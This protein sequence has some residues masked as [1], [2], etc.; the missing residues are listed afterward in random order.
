MNVGSFLR[1]H[2]LGLRGVGVS[3]VTWKC[4]S[5]RPSQPDRVWPWWLKHGAEVSFLGLTPQWT[6]CP[7]TIPR[8]QSE[9]S[10]S[11]VVSYV[12]PFR[13]RQGTKEVADESVHIHYFYRGETSDPL[14]IFPKAQTNPGKAVKSVNTDSEIRAVPFPL[15]CFSL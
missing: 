1:N 14:V 9:T 4:G 15:H 5:A 3:S 6:C 2:T 7:G 10:F 11:A 12:P 13:L 8:P